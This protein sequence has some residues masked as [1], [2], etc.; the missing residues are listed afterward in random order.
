MK[1]KVLFVMFVLVLLVGCS[2]PEKTSKETS[3]DSPYPAECANVAVKEECVG[4]LAAESDDRNMCREYFNRDRIDVCLL[5][6]GKA[7]EDPSWCD[8]VDD[9]GI[10]DYKLCI[11]HVAKSAKDPSLCE[12][13]TERDPDASIS[14]C[15][16]VA[17][18]G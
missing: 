7:S 11:Q 1:F 9:D 2:E 13:I 8:D 10:T 16:V 4:E 17:R 12:L 5:H 15:E 18:R 3:D 6:A 14:S